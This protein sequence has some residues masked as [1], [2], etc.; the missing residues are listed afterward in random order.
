M[1]RV[2]TDIGEQHIAHLLSQAANQAEQL[3]TD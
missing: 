2:A 3:L 1:Q